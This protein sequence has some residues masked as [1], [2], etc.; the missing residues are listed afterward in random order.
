MAALIG[1]DSHSHIVSVQAK[2][3]E[4]RRRERVQRM[5]RIEAWSQ[6]LGR[7]A[8][9]YLNHPQ[10]FGFGGRDDDQFEDFGYP[11]FLRNPAPFRAIHCTL[12]SLMAVLSLE[13]WKKPIMQ[14]NRN[15]ETR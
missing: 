8:Q 1:L 7:R 13:P 5:N 3:A 15:W 12:P 9:G 2:L 6:A 14:E 10:N 4:E 11:I